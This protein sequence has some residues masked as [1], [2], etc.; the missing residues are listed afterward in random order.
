MSYYTVKWLS[1][2]IVSLKF[3]KLRV[4][5]EI[6]LNKNLLRSLLFNSE[7]LWKFIAADSIFLNEFN[8]KLEVQHTCM[9]NLYWDKVIS[10]PA[11]IVWI[12]SDVKLLYPLPTLSKI[13]TRC[14]ISNRTQICHRHISQNQTTIL[15]AFRR[16]Q[17]KSTCH[18]SKTIQLCNKELPCNPQLE[19][20]SLQ[21]NDLGKGKYQEKNLGPAPWT[22][23]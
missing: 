11:D 12:T 1:S 18:I 5:T 8:L 7:G 17:Y 22:N 9:Q 6:F 10:R 14:K 2:G 21:C 16:P 13:K 19:V 15:A 23:G 20:I 4:E 3:F